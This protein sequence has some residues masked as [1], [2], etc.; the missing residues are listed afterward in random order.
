MIDESSRNQRGEPS[1]D[2]TGTANQNGLA[3]RLSALARSLELQP[4]LQSIL[5]TVVRAAVGTVPGA[6]DA[7]IS[8]IQRRR[9]VK[10]LAATG[11][12]PRAADHAQY[13]L[14]EGP[15]LDALYDQETVRL[16]DLNAE[17]RWPRFVVRARELGVGSMLAVQ[18]FVDAENLGALNLVSRQAYAF[19]D[20]SEHVALLF[21]SHASVAMSG[22]RVR[23]HLKAAVTTRELIGQAQGILMERF[24]ITGE[25]AF[26]MLMLISQDS[27]R[28]LRDIADDLVATGELPA[29]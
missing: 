18:L 10:T 15:C 23:G 12:L 21:A 29:T 1:S 5:D 4:D 8:E 16:S 7:S 25:I 14:G 9:D 20:E 22:E 28:K 11:E 27:N 17:K 3:D 2:N 6:T 13:D 26:H 19:D 24:K